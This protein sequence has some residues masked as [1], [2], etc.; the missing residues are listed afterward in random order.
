L[1]VEI[2]AE[3]VER[4]IRHFLAGIQPDG[5]GN[6]ANLPVLVTLRCQKLDIIR[7]LKS[8]PAMPK[9]Y[10]ASRN[11]ELE[12]GGSGAT[13]LISGADMEKYRV[14]ANLLQTCPISPLLHFFSGAEFYPSPRRQDDWHF[15]PPTWFV[16]SECFVQRQGDEYTLGVTTLYHPGM[17][18]D[19]L[20]KILLTKIKN[21][22]SATA[23]IPHPILPPVLKRN[24]QPD[25][26]GW[27]HN[28]QKSLHL[29]ETRQIQKVVLARKTTLTFAAPVDG[30]TLLAKLRQR[31]KNCF[32]YFV[33]PTSNAIFLGA[34]PERLFEVEGDILTSEAVSGTVA[35]QNSW[36]E[37]RRSGEELL[38]S[39]KNLREHRFVLD[40]ILNMFNSLCTEIK[41][42]S[43][44]E[45]LEL[46]NVQHLFSL[47]QGRLQPEITLTDIVTTIQ[48]TPA[49]GGTPR[50]QAIRLIEQLEPF[51]RGWY[52][53]PVGIISQQCAELAVALRSLLIS[54]SQAHLYAGAGIVA[55]SDPEQ[56]WQELDSK[57]A[58]AMKLFHGEPD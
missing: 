41:W 33:Q 31:N 52:A 25:F 7:W 51:D 26:S 1:I 4:Q 27:T 56:E 42:Q 15:F 44:P 9:V 14:I 37:D 38:H 8:A 39:D 47:V 28:V 21:R 46:A 30:Y 40:A 10:W 34:T 11:G 5:N 2:D 32:V 23:Q 3:E 12:I 43:Q 54:G 19:E 22:I 17:T 20:T 45:L 6:S 55:G 53:G 49:A 48:P 13:I 16:L 29:I 36:S 18:G 58:I 57:I 35:R 50:L 24:D